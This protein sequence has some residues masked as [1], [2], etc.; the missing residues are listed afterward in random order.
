MFVKSIT[1]Y[2]S[3][4]MT[5]VL[6]RR[7]INKILF[8][9]HTFTPNVPFDTHEIS[10]YFIMATRGSRGINHIRRTVEILNCDRFKISAKIDVQYKIYIS[11][12]NK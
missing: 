4:F 6:L 1:Q 10:A 12:Q 9:F 7:N 5:D 8:F 2:V 11:L 3:I